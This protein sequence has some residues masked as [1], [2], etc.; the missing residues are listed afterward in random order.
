MAYWIFRSSIGNGSIFT[1]FFLMLVSTQ[2]IQKGNMK[3][4][5]LCVHPSTDAK[6]SIKWIFL[7]PDT[8]TSACVSGGKKRLFF[9][10]KNLRT[11]QMDVTSKKRLSPSYLSGKTKVDYFIILS[12][13]GTNLHI[14]ITP[15]VYFWFVFSF[16][17]NFL[18]RKNI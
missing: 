14:C 12:T 9:S 1:S 8:Q 6:C 11:Y 17:L 10:K 7:N 2:N 5:Q 16:L 13:W 18:N 15:R 3:K 4:T